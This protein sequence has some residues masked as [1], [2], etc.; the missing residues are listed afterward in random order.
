MKNHVAGVTALAEVV[1]TVF[2]DLAE[3]GKGVGEDARRAR[4]RRS[5]ARGLV[6]EPK[7][8][9]RHSLCT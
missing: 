1:R 9:S 5:V 4:A 7:P 2:A 8:A 3:R 6:A